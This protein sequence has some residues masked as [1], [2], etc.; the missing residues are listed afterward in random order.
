MPNSPGNH[1]KVYEPFVAALLVCQAPQEASRFSSS[2]SAPALGAR[3]GGWHTR[4]LTAAHVRPA[5]EAV[6][7][8]PPTHT[9][10]HTPT[11]NTYCVVSREAIKMLN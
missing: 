5:M 8:K 10:R 6:F 4:C 1:A 11:A 9:H 2:N 7:H 3:K